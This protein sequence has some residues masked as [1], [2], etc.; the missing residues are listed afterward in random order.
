[1]SQWRIYLRDAR[2]DTILA[3][4]TLNEKMIAAL[5]DDFDALCDFDN[6]K[7][8]LSEYERAV[9]DKLIELKEYNGEDEILNTFYNSLWLTWID[10]IETKYPVLR[11]INSMKFENMQLEMQEAVKEKLK[12]SRFITLLKARER[13]YENVEFNRLNNMVSY[14]E[15]AHQVTKKRQVWPIRK[16]IQNFDRE[17]FDL[18]PCWMASPEAVSAI[19]PMEKLFDLVIF[20]EASQCFVE[21]GIPAMYRGKQIV[22]AGDS[23]QLS[24]FDLYK[25]RW[26]DQEE[27]ED[28]S[29]EVDSLLD[30]SSQYLMQVQ[31]RGHYRSNSLDLIDFSNQHFYNGRLTLLPDKHILD[32][33]KPAIEYIKIDGVWSN[34]TN[35]AEAEKVTA[36]VMD[37]IGRKP[38]KEIG[39][40]T[41][42]TRQQDLIQDVLEEKAIEKGV[43]I[44]QSLFIK[45]IENVQG[46]ERDII[47]FSIGYAPDEKGHIHHH[48]GSLNVQKGENRLNVAI[49]RAREKIIV[50]SSIFPQQLKVEETRN[51]G[52]KLL[53]KYLEYAMQVSSGAFKP[54][55]SDNS[56]HRA[57]WYLKHKIQQLE[58]EQEVDIEMTEEM[59]FADLTI[60][61]GGRYKGLVLTDDD[62]YHQSISIKDMHVYTPFTLSAKHW[63]F[64]GVYSR[65]FWHNKEAIKER[66]LKFAPEAES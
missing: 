37:L 56:K 40:V 38:E 27:P 1:M 18:L 54:V 47:I 14:R 52:P 64:I 17:L 66:L 62:L 65:E 31:L 55:I 41:F 19:F 23:M 44:P 42:N 30:L 50:V 8:E 63:K 60:K 36:L 15:L 49:T 28:I 29:L 6:L 46:D 3:D 26:E 2:I 51:E 10:H 48:F 39:I 43:L 4:A 53:R 35:R 25:V 24:P 16:L 61:S 34:Q 22:V 7:H 45:N 5:S 9:I 21:Q 59:P 13:T 57:D 32:E 11:S 20:D 33:G 58:F 12:I